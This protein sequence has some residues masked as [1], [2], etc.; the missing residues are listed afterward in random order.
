MPKEYCLICD[1]ANNALDVLSRGRGLSITTSFV[2]S[3]AFLFFT[4]WGTYGW[5]QVFLSLGWYFLGLI[6][7]LLGIFGLIRVTLQ[8]QLESWQKAFGICCFVIALTAYLMLQW[9]KY[10]TGFFSGSQDFAAGRFILIIAIALGC[11]LLGGLRGLGKRE[12]RIGGGLWLWASFLF[13]FNF[14]VL[15]TEL[16]KSYY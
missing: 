3:T 11:L 2:Q 14:A 7:T 16:Y 6:I 9:V 1:Y 4:S 5:G 8:F 13:V 12:S 10:W 15:L